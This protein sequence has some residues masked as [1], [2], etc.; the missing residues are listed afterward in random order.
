MRAERAGRRPTREAIADRG[1]SARSSIELFA[2]RGT[3]APD[4]RNFGALSGPAR[5]RTLTVSLA[6]EI[7]PH[8][9]FMEGN[10][11]FQGGTEI[12]LVEDVGLDLLQCSHRR[13]TRVA[14]D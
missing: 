8:E 11:Q 5:S 14:G 10:A 3:A 1:Y 6:L 7:H 12:L 2:T 13:V 9:L 4:D